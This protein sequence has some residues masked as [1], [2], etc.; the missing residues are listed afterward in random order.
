MDELKLRECPFCGEQKF[1]DIYGIY[2]NEGQEIG[3]HITCGGCM[4]HFEFE[5]ATCREDVIAAWNRR[6]EK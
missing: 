5:E 4:A 6:A 1:I 2:N 3:S